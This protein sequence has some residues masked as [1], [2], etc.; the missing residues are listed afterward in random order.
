MST[1]PAKNL[2]PVSTIAGV[3]DTC[4]K[5]IAGDNETGEQLSPV[6]TTPVINYCWCQEQGRYGGGELP[7]IE[8]S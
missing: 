3:F 1:T 5:F 6:T 2:S 7:K 4:D 8:E